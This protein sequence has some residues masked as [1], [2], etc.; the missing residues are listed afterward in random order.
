MTAK[1]HIRSSFVTIRK[2]ISYKKVNEK[3]LNWTPKGR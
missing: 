1:T 3:V 2:S